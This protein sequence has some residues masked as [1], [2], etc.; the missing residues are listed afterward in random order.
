MSAKLIS[1]LSNCPIVPLI[2]AEDPDT[3]V[4]IARALAAGGLPLVEVVQRTAASLECLTAIIEACPDLVTGAGTVLSQRQCETCID[5]GASFIVS[6]GLD[7]D[8]V[9]C[10]LD[11]EVGVLP[12]IMTPSEAQQAHNLGLEAVKFFPATIAGGVPALKAMASVFR[13][14]RFIPTGGIS[15]ANV[16]EFLALPAVVA[17]GG[18]W[19]TPADAIASGDFDTITRLAKEALTI[20]DNTSGS[21]SP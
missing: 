4:R 12:G 10:A 8:V 15:A 16:A 2:Q 11:R 1:R 13:N 21:K 14:M 5:A 17:C 9:A 18:S 7:E 19:L 6:P 3:A 20:A